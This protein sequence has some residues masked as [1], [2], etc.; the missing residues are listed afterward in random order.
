[1]TGRCATVAKIPTVP[2]IWAISTKVHS[3]NCGF[4]SVTQKYCSILFSDVGNTTHSAE[5]ARCHQRGRVNNRE[6]VSKSGLASFLQPWV[7][8]GR[9]GL[10]RL[11]PLLA[12]LLPSKQ[13]HSWPVAV[14]AVLHAME[15]RSAQGLPLRRATRSGVSRKRTTSRTP[16]PAT[17][18]NRW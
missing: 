6:N 12:A 14:A 16:S 1:M 5:T 15:L 8:E 17:S 3:R 10:A 11:G 7:E 18:S 2:S 4:L 13:T 9:E